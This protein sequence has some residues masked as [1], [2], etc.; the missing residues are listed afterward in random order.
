MPR[1]EKTG[2]H[3]YLY[4]YGEWARCDVFRT[5]GG[6]LIARIAV[7]ERHPLQK[8][9]HYRIDKIDEWWDRDSI[10]GIS[11]LLSDHGGFEYLGYEG[12]PIEEMY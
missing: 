7:Y 1:C 6:A 3:I 9:V 4:E 11:T 8:V 12:V 2:A 10:H 5:N